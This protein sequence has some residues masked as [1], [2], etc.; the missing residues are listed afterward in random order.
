MGQGQTVIKHALQRSRKG[1]LT[2]R[3]LR[4]TEQQGE[5]LRC[6][7][8]PDLGK[9]GT[10]FI[11]PVHIKGDNGIEGV[12]VGGHGREGSRQELEPG[13]GPKT[14]LCR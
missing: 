3:G 4:R 9:D 6:Q 1:S 5:T 13:R 2:H 10:R 12:S 11:R 8:P 7:N 14:C